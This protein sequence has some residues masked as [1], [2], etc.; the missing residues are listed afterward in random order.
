MQYLDIR[1][2]YQLSGPIPPELGNL[3]S[4]ENL[5]LAVN[6]LEG[7]IP[8]EL[9]SLSNLVRLVLVSNRLTGPIPSELGNLTKLEWLKLYSNRLTGS[10]P[11]ELGNLI[12]LSTL[13]LFENTNIERLHG[14]RDCAVAAPRRRQSAQARR[15]L[16]RSG[17]VP[18]RTRHSSG[19][20]SVT[21][22]Y[23]TQSKHCEQTE[24]PR[25]AGS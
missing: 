23:L 18:R 3:S 19:N 21:L 16:Q 4:L 2:N 13:E 22:R 7:P 11:A 20:A 8:P 14:Q 6:Q 12:G 25:D 17:A 9:G 10:I 1:S 15:Y 24:A 5:N